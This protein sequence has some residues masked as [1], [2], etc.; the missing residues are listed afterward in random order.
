M[1]RRQSEPTDQAENDQ[2]A[3]RRRLHVAVEGIDAGEYKAGDTHVRCDIGAVRDHVWLKNHQCQCEQRRTVAEHLSRCQKDEQSEQETEGCR[4]HPGA[5]ND[6]VRFG[7]STIT[8][9]EIPSIRVC[10]VF[11]VCI[12]SWN[13]AP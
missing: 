3:D 6:A 11:E 4:R 8:E 2:P 13:L 9:D 1:F 10:F 5:E 12:R 7:L